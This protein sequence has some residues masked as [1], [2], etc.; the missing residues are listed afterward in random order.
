MLQSTF[1]TF[2]TKI[3]YHARPNDDRIEAF[4][5]RWSRDPLSHPDIRK[6]TSREIADLPID[7]EL[8]DDQ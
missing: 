7:P 6:M 2:W 8:I 5:P 3:K 1:I 4:D